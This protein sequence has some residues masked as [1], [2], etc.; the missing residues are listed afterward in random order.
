M[1][2]DVP[3]TPPVPPVSFGS[4]A[5]KET[6]DGQSPY[7]DVPDEDETC[8]VHVNHRCFPRLTI[9]VTRILFAPW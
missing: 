1:R 9:A 5:I 8:V 7:H 2:E 4:C 6:Q 3:R